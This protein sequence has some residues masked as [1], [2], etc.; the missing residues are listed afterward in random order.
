MK[1]LG[2]VLL[3]FYISFA[4][5]LKSLASEPDYINDAPLESLLSQG[6]IHEGGILRSIISL[7][8]V[9]GLIYVTAWL[10]KKLNCFNAQKFTKEVEGAD[11]NKFKVLASQSLGAN[12]NLHVV[13]IN[14]KYLVLG[15]T[16]NNISLLKEFDKSLFDNKINLQEQTEAKEEKK[17]DTWMNDIVN[18]YDSLED[19]DAKWD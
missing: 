5:E 9:I 13:E 8:I 16:Q 1:K 14:G 12:K 4:F 17:I 6:T 7:A 2:L 11:I 15:S 3:G 19:G 18:K 10:Y